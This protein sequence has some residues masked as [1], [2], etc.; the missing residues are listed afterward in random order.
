MAIERSVTLICDAGSE[1]LTAAIDDGDVCFTFTDASDTKSTVYV[2]KAEARDFAN[3]IN[4][5]AAEDF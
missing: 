1:Q 2:K 3:F 5:V 4:Q